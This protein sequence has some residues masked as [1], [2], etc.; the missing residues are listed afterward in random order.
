MTSE[1][2]SKIKSPAIGLIA[3]GILNLLLGAIFAF[4]IIFQAAVG[5]LSRPFSSEEERLYFFVGYYG[6]VV[7]ALI[8][9]AIAPIL[10]YAGIQMLKGRKYGFARIAS[11]LAI[12]PVTSFCF[13]VGIPIGIWSFIVLRKPE[14]KLYFER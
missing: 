6:V 8:G 5:Q 4:R 12:F 14:I 1:I 11:I 9:T 2:E 13:P 7:F 3:V 10:I